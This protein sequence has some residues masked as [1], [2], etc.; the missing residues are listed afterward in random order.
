MEIMCR[1]EVFGRR[2][3][4]REFTSRTKRENRCPGAE[5]EVKNKPRRGMWARMS[6]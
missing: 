2:R 1:E 3:R 6:G 4:F 5:R